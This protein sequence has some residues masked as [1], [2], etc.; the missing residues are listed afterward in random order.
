MEEVEYEQW[1]RDLKNSSGHKKFL[2]YMREIIE[3][4]Y[5][6]TFIKDTRKR[7]SIPN[8]GFPAKGN[9]RLFPPEKWVGRDNSEIYKQYREEIRVFSR[10]YHWHHL[11]GIDILDNYIFYNKTDFP[12]S[13]NSF[14]VCMVADLVGEKE[15][16]YADVTQ[17]DDDALF[18]IAV[19]ISPYASLRD[20]LD[21][22][23]RA[24]KYEIKFLQEQYREKG[25]KLGKFKKR[26]TSIQERNEFIYQNRNLPRKEIMRLV[27]DKFGGNNSIDYGYIGKIISMEKKKRKEL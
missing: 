14:N 3:S 6:Q 26:K 8:D 12:F 27:T 20:I 1:M 23:R 19:R 13:P 18:P 24:Y 17:E 16:P 5:F 22:I 9:S 15:E 10:K 7:Y 11:D 25:I 4:E 2:N 21:F